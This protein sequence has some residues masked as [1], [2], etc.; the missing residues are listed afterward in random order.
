MNFVRNTLE[1]FKATPP[2]AVGSIN[3][4]ISG[5]IDPLSVGANFNVEPPTWET[6]SWVWGGVSTGN[7]NGGI[8]EGITIANRDLNGTDNTDLFKACTDLTFTL[9]TG[10]TS[11]IISAPIDEKIYYAGYTFFKVRVPIQDLTGLEVHFYKDD[12]DNFLGYTCK[13]AN[14][15]ATLLTI[16]PSIGE[17]STVELES[18]TPTLNNVLESRLS[19]YA[20]NVEIFISPIYRGSK[21]K[22]SL[23]E[24]R[25]TTSASIEDGFYESYA[26]ASGRFLGTKNGIV[27]DIYLCK[28][29]Y[30][31]ASLVEAEEEAVE[32]LYSSS[33]NYPL[34]ETLSSTLFSG[35]IQFVKENYSGSAGIFDPG[36]VPVKLY[37]DCGV[38]MSVSNSV[39][40]AIF[41][42]ETVIGKGGLNGLGQITVPYISGSFIS[43]AYI[44]ADVD[45]IVSGTLTDTTDIGAEF[46]GSITTCNPDRCL[47][48][49]NYDHISIN[50]TLT[51]GST[52][53]GNV[54]GRLRGYFSGSVN[55]VRCSGSISSNY[56][57]GEIIGHVSGGLCS[58][59]II[60]NGISGTLEGPINIV[61]ESE[62]LV[63]DPEFPSQ[64]TVLEHHADKIAAVPTEMPFYN[65]HTI[66]N[67]FILPVRTEVKSLEDINQLRTAGEG[68]TRSLT[69]MPGVMCISQS[70]GMW[71]LKGNVAESNSNRYPLVGDIL[72]EGNERVTASKIFISPVNRLATLDRNGQVSEIS[73]LYNRPTVT[74]QTASINT[75]GAD[76]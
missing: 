75:G 18:I 62:K 17:I 63:I 49:Q 29:T 20:Q 11:V 33:V 60:L 23:E 59:N 32:V 30:T 10:D 42:E 27:S 41:S 28:E 70:N 9:E 44:N 66:S 50:T 4:L 69:V 73:T 64:I 48:P 34:G 21:L 16:M 12:S 54:R 55:L 58:N 15:N 56:F 57:S 38:S 26:N 76:Q 31:S 3:V 68:Y 8:V 45:G 51:S 61:R 72:Y 36:K 71:Y 24:D 43:G 37:V 52:I 6:G 1:L 25:C 67:C 13:S 53:N 2:N 46:S 22:G 47:P 14:G 7:I 19:S 5:T 74:V 40:E 35:Q 39:L 65:L